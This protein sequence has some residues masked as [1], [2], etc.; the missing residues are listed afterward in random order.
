MLL[1]LEDL[2]ICLSYVFKRT[3]HTIDMH[4]LKIKMFT[5]VF[6]FSFGMRALK[7][8]KINTQKFDSRSFKIQEFAEKINK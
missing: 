8:Y 1:F 2:V 6:F 5:R 3:E 4:L 7:D